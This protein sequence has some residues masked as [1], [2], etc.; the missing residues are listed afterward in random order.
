V[1]LVAI[2]DSVVGLV[3]VVVNLVVV[4]GFAVVVAIG[5]LVVVVVILVAE[6]LVVVLRVVVV[7]VVD[8]LAVVVRVVADCFAVVVV[9]EVTWLFSVVNTVV[10]VAEVPFADV[11]EVVT[12][13]VEFSAAADV[14]AVVDSG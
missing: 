11:T 6:G 8:C 2:G 3:V 7:R 14:F 5:G 12:A 4:C 10:I 1:V 9:F 13:A